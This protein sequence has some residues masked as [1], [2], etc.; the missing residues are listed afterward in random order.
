MKRSS[1][2]AAILQEIGKRVRRA[3]AAA[4]LTQEEAA[5]LAQIDYKHW[6]RVEQGVVNPTI[7]TLCRIADTLGVTMWEML[8]PE[9][10]TKE[11][12]SRR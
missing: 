7:Q 5:H 12:R 2:H 8:E 11:R 4:G 6:Q 9:P 1:A 3:R 10:A